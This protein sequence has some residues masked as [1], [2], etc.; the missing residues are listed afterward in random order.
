[1]A[2]RKNTRA[3]ARRTRKPSPP[4]L[5]THQRQMAALTFK[6]VEDCKPEKFGSD[7][8]HGRGLRARVAASLLAIDSEEMASRFGTSSKTMDTLL[9]TYDD[10]KGEVEYCLKQHAELKAAPLAAF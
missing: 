8:D 5:R 1:M 7:W 4:Q 3:A 6:A 10:L 2:S 9:Y